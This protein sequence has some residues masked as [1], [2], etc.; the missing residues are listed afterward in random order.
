MET[1]SIPTT[2]PTKDKDNKKKKADDDTEV[3]AETKRGKKKKM[4]DSDDTAKSSSKK[5]SKRRKTPDFL[6][7]FSGGEMLTKAPET[8]GPDDVTKNVK[9]VSIEGKFRVKMVDP[10]GTKSIQVRLLHEDGKTIVPMNAKN[11]F[12]A[13]TTQQVMDFKTVVLNGKLRVIKNGA[14]FTTAFVKLDDK[15]SSW[16]T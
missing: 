2:E 11:F 6:V 9:D 1:K 14:T 16:N 7:P 5:Q 13:L 3:K 15:K 4:E 10:D 12:E 8:P